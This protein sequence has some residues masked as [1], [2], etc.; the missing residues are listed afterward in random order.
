MAGDH[1]WQGNGPWVIGL[2]RFEDSLKNGPMTF[3]FR[4]L[5]HDAPFLGTI[6]QENIPSFDDGA[7]LDVREIS[8][9]PQYMT[10]IK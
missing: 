6:P 7:V 3:Y 10:V 5:K 8:L 1:L 9:V 4:A 2:N